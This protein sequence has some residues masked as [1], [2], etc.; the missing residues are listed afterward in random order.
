M[1][2]PWASRSAETRSPGNRAPRDTRRTP[3][4]TGDREGTPP[5]FRG[6]GPNLPASFQ[7]LLQVWFWKRGKHARQGQPVPPLVPPISQGRKEAGRQLQTPDPGPLG[8][9]SGVRWGPGNA[10]ARVAQKPLVTMA[11]A[12]GPRGKGDI[13]DVNRGP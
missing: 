1:D 5:P 12:E 13:W 2:P 6:Q 8:S 7:G 9:A 4:L 11:P 10:G 3:Q